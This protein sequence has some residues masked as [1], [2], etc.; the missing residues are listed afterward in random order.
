[1]VSFCCF[2]KYKKFEIYGLY[3][4]FVGNDIID[5][6]KFDFDEYDI[7]ISV[8][9]AAAIVRSRACA[10]TICI[11]CAWHPLTSV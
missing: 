8:A 10:R 11:V 1:M 7:I 6:E 9:A 2:S 3:E 5:N 4:N